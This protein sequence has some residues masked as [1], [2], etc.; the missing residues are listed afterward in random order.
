MKERLIADRYARALGECLPDA[1]QKED[2]ARALKALTTFYEEDAQFRHTVTNPTLPTQGRAQLLTSATQAFKAPESLQR[3]LGLL[4]ERNRMA[5]LPAVCAEFQARV[6]EWLNRVEVTVVTVVP[7]PDDERARL[8][9]TLEKFAGRTVRLNSVIDPTII[10]G[11]IVY[12][13]GVHFDFSLRTRFEH[14]KQ[15][16]LAEESLNYG[17]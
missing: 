3:L 13:W 17:Y 9:K 15:K 4:L 14:L 7:L 10:G 2:A 1:A 8:V 6:D 12:I 5:L 16:L 11:L